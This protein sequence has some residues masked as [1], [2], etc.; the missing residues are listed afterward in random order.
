[1]DDVREVFRML[2]KRKRS[3]VDGMSVLTYM[4]VLAITSEEGMS[5]PEACLYLSH[6]YEGMAECTHLHP[7]PKSRAKRKTKSKNK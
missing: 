1:M 5:I 4:P 6:F 3:H 2:S 7:K